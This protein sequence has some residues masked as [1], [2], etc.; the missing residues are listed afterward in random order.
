MNLLRRLFGPSPA[1]NPPSQLAGQGTHA[2]VD[3][4]FAGATGWYGKLPSLGDFAS[5]RIA[6]EQIECLDGWMSAALASWQK[7]MPDFQ[8]QY[9]HAPS[10]SMVLGP[11]AWPGLGL[12]PHAPRPVAAAAMTAYAGVWMPSMDR[13]GRLFP[14]IVL[15][16]LLNWPQSQSDLSAVIGWLVLTEQR[17]LAAVQGDWSP[18]Q[19]DAELADLDRYALAKLAAAATTQETSWAG[20]S[21]LA[22]PASAW[23]RHG[24]DQLT[25]L[26][27]P[28]QAHDLPMLLGLSA[29]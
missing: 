27:E 25:V 28:A 15:R 26:H 2:R 18:D 5:R 21:K 29:I 24:S 19:L 17:V 13:T 10:L 3:G 9:L 1:P 22:A 6:V 7:A 12:D 23:M 20:L 16:P 8:N 4:P 11:K 14:L